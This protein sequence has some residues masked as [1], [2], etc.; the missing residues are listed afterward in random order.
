MSWWRRPALAAV[1]LT[2]GV[3]IAGAQTAA[4]GSDAV[5]YRIFLR[6]GSMLVSYGEFARVADRVVLSIPIG[7]TGENPVL[8]LLSIAESEVE[9]ARTD[10]YMQAAR[11]RHYAAT[12]GEEDFAKLTRDVADVLYQVGSVSDAGRR[13]ALAEY[14]RRQ[15]VEWPEQHYGYRATELAQMTTWLDQ[16]VSELRVAAGQSSFDLALV[17]T[18]TPTAIPDVAILPAPNLRE[19][20][21]IAMLAA[22]KTPDPA[23]R[24]ALLRAIVDAIPPELATDGTWSA[25]LRTRANTELAAELKA[26]RAYADLTAKSLTRAAAY[27]KRADVR[28][29]ESLIR[30]VLEQDAGLSR[31]RPAEMAALL[32]TLDARLDSARRLRLAQDAWVLRSAVLRQYWS[33]VRTGL[34]RLLGVR[35]WLTD[36]RQLAGPSPGALR[37]MTE[38][39]ALA[40]HE[41]S[42]VH[43]PAEVA[44]AHSTLSSASMMVGR[45]AAARLDAIRSGNMDIAWQASSA[46]AGALML[47]DEAVQEL[48]RITRMPAPR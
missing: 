6:D 34:D 44:A 22:H 18:A 12:R 39:A 2:A 33:D 36:V 11:A 28:G 41:L 21:E 4:G 42:Q 25:A 9:W 16:V 13:L 24:V 29:L 47:L 45:A 30:S 32:A 8:H 14:A 5:L 20:T 40:R 7:G 19:R 35:E 3:S 17:A 37:R 1:V 48:R 31:A 43:A 23:E 38:A 46:A 10:A 27:E 26:D 15:L